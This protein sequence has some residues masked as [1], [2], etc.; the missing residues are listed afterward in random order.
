MFIFS[1]CKS[2]GNKLEKISIIVL[3]IL[4]ICSFNRLYL[5]WQKDYYYQLAMEDELTNELI[6]DNDT[7]FLADLNE[8]EISGQRFYGLNVNGYHVYQ[9]KDRVFLPKVGNITMLKS[10]D[11]VEFNKNLLHS[12]YYMEDYNPDDYYLDAVIVY[13][14]EMSEYEVL[15]LKYHEIF[16]KDLFN[17]EIKEYGTMSVIE[18]DDDFTELLFDRIDN[19]EINSDEDL[20]LFLIDYKE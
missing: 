20:L 10:K 13:E 15:M 7:F 3:T 6:R 4:G 8:S 5:E 14:C 12:A 2:F 17:K 9:T 18:V 16:N 11:S 1:I 19:G